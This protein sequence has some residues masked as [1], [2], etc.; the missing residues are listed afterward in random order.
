[1]EMPY[2]GLLVFSVNVELSRSEYFKFYMQI[3]DIYASYR[4]HDT[5]TFHLAHI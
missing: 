3:V 1:M 4:I 2:D 5:C